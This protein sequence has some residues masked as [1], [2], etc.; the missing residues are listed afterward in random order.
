MDL[1]IFSDGGARGNPGPA[2]FGVVVQNND[3]AKAIYMCGQYLG[4]KTNNEAEYLGLIHALTWLRDNQENLESKNITFIS[5]S[6]LLLRQILGR[7]KVKAPHLK[8]LHQQ[9][10]ALKE[11]I[12]L[13]IHFQEVLRNKNT[14]ADA[15]ANRAMDLKTTVYGL[16]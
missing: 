5:D 15:L 7:Y 12:N 1:Q 16:E 10:L 6:Q 3:S 14:Q 13:P 8:L 2:G 11:Q 9:A 4:V